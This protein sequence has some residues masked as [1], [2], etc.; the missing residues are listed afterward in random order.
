MIDPID[1]GVLYQMNEGLLL[2][3]NGNT[4]DWNAG[5]PRWVIHAVS[6]EGVDK[7]ERLGWIKHSGD[8]YFA[9]TDQ[10]RAVYRQERL[11]QAS[12]SLLDIGIKIERYP[13]CSW[14]DLI[15]GDSIRELNVDDIDSLMTAL[16]EAKRS[17]E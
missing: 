3:E 2:Y 12:N 4:L 5:K 10:G 15:V 14:V 17:L 6:Y 16:Q 11:R 9:I 13:Q 8:G 1:Y 7:L